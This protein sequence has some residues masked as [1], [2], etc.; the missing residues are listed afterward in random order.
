MKYIVHKGYSYTDTKNR[1]RVYVAGQEF[2]GEVDPTQKW[3]LG[4]LDQAPEVQV[5]K[6]VTA[7]AAVDTYDEMDEGE[8]TE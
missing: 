5:A 7:K 3:K 4:Q 8:E 6:K 2:E 1:N